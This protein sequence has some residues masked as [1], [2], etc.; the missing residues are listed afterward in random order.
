MPVRIFKHDRH[1]LLKQGTEINASRN[2]T[3]DHNDEVSVHLLIRGKSTARQ[4]SHQE[5]AVVVLGVV[6]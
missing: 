6:C 3:R 2:E 4:Q 1:E 5:Y